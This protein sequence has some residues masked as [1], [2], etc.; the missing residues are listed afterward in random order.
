MA[1]PKLLFLMASLLVDCHSLSPSSSHFESLTGRRS[2]M[3]IAAGTLAGTTTLGCQQPEVAAA[4]PDGGSAY[5]LPPLP[6]SYKALA[7]YISEKTVRLHHDKHH[8][9]YID[10]ANKAVADMKKAPSL[11]EL[12][13]NAIKS[14][15]ALARNGGGGAYNHAMFW[16]ELGPPS[17]N[18]EPS[19]ALSA[20]INKS[21]GSMEDFQKQFGDAAA[22]VFGSGWAW[23]CVTKD[24]QLVI[25][26]TKNQQRF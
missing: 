23:L 18:G 24:K 3:K 19:A 11:L 25:V 26:S 7:P 16:Q 2:W 13:R 21:F 17:A 22:K 8:R 9:V 15:S 1:W 4:F 20:A 14:G 5:E 10:N 6:Y 12:Q